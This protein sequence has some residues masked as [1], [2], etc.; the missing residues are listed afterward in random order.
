MKIILTK[1]K[2]RVNAIKASSAWQPDVTNFKALTRHV[3]QLIGALQ[4]G[5]RVKKKF[6]VHKN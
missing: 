5:G 6:A 4:V 2:R 1:W 3:Q